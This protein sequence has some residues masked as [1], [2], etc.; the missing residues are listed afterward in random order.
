[1]S[2]WTILLGLGM[3]LWAVGM[4][5]AWCLC[6]VNRRMPED[7]K[8]EWDEQPFAKCPACGGMVEMW[9][10]DKG[11]PSPWR[12]MWSR[13]IGQTGQTHWCSVCNCWV[14]PREK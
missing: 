7:W 12:G 5:V 14:K 11:Q 4:V 8:Q 1:M 3:F 13:D 2:T 10:R 9:S 6:A